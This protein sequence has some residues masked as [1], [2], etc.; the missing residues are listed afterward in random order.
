MAVLNKTVDALIKALCWVGMAVEFFLMFF[1]FVAVAGRS[2]NHPIIGDVEV[3]QYG[4]LALIA[5]G[6]AYTQSRNGHITIGLIVDHFPPRLQKVIDIIGLL[7]IAGTSWIITY[8]FIIAVQSQFTEIYTRSP[9]LRMPDFPFK[10]FIAIG[11]FIWGLEAL[12]QTI[13]A[14]GEL[15][16][17]DFAKKETGEGVEGGWM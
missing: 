4:M 8:V 17:G 1:I 11:F 7:I 5:C 14:V 9:L 13:K 16:R 15:I 12:L 2:L 6:L 10:A 3:V